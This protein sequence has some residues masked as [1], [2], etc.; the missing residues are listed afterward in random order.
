M[1]F[2]LV[3]KKEVKKESKITRN[4]QDKSLRKTTKE[5][6]ENEGI[7]KYTN[8]RRKKAMKMNWIDC[9]EGKEGD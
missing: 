8:I 3:H 7:G 2:S 6:A 1:F 4:V 5:W 9:R